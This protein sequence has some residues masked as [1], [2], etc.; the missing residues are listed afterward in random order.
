MKQNQMDETEA[1]TVLHTFLKRKGYTKSHWKEAKFNFYVDARLK[2]LEATTV[3]LVKELVEWPEYEESLKRYYPSAS[4]DKT[5][6]VIN[7]CSLLSDRRM[8]QSLKRIFA[9]KGFDLIE[10]YM[11]VDKLT[12]GVKPIRSLSAR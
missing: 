3:S 9:A 5:R 11:G 8:N 2:D 10:R 4:I 1:L 7:L 12:R 6:E